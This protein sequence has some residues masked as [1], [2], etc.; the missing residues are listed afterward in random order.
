MLTMSF[1]KAML[2]VFRWGILTNGNKWTKGSF[3]SKL[4][5]SHQITV[6]YIIISYQREYNPLIKA[7][8]FFNTRKITNKAP[9]L[10][11]TVPVNTNGCMG[12]T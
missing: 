7:R 1:S 9:Y 8:I 2:N 10:F 5:Y 3:V 4:H 11:F 6:I 12:S